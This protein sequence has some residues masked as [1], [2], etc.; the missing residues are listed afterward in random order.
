ML[1]YLPQLFK[2]HK[3]RLSRDV[4]IAT[5]ALV[6]FGDLALLFRAVYDAKLTFVI[7]Y[8]IGAVLSLAIVALAIFYRNNHN[9]GKQNL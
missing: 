5:W 9:Q 1:S 8:V 4:S 2:I 3:T 7:N 6:L